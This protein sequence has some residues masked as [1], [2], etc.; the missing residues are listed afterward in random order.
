MGPTVSGQG[1]IKS[2]QDN[3]V[4]ALATDDSLLLMTGESEHVA[5]AILDKE[6][7]LSSLAKSCLAVGAAGG[8]SSTS[9]F[10]SEIKRLGFDLQVSWRITQVNVDHKLCPTYPEEILVP[11]SVSDADLVKAASFRWSRRIPSVVYRHLRTGAILARCSQPEVGILGWRSKEDEKV[12]RVSTLSIIPR[13]CRFCSLRE[14]SILSRKSSENVSSWPR[15]ITLQK[16][17]HLGSTVFQDTSHFGKC[18]I[19]ENS[20]P[21]MPRFPKCDASCPRC[22]VF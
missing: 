7:T 2:K 17:W 4:Q 20:T 3:H 6:D 18:G 16:T 12:I 19:L 1:L 5:N 8:C 10:Q 11:H 13:F 9:W 21:K 14:D 15:Y 22:H